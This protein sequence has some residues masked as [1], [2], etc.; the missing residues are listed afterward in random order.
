MN[1]RLLLEHIDYV[2]GTI[3]IEGKTYK[4]LDT[5]FPTIDP[6]DPYRLTDEEEEV[7]N[8][9]RS[10]FIHCD[11]LKTHVKLLLKKGSMYKVYNGNLLFHGCI[12]F[13]DYGEFA[14][15]Y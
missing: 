3:E 9:L 4:M 6:D 2:K 10:S 12:P 13:D 5:Y 14:K 11:K 7:M 8:R 1:D 15:V